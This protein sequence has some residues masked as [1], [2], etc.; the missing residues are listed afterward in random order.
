MCDFSSQVP[1][2]EWSA[3]K[4]VQVVKRFLKKTKHAREAF[5]VA[6]LNYSLS[7]LEG[8][9]S[10]AEMLMG[11]RLR[12]RLPDFAVQP[13]AEVKKHMQKPRAGTSL[14]VL[15]RGDTVRILDD[16]RWTV[17]AAIQDRVDP[18]SYVLRTEEGHTRRQNRQR[19]RKTDERFMLR[20]TEEEYE[21]NCLAR[22]AGKPQPT[23]DYPP[24]SSVVQPGSTRESRDNHAEIMPAA[25]NATSST[26]VHHL[27]M[28]QAMAPEQAGN[29]ANN[30]GAVDR[31]NDT[32]QRVRK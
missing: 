18:R 12:G 28:M 10:P 22:D 26:A 1:E 8:G 27:T 6:L 21:D 16:S 23:E 4:G 13:A 5:W 20:D 29:Q 31:C 15:A 25:E 30:Q 17:K 32:G 2:S 19:I 3:E 24:P 9:M 14:P 11:R 7:P